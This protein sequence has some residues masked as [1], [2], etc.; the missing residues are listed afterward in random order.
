MDKLTEQR[1]NRNELLS[2]F[3]EIR[4]VGTLCDPL[5]QKYGEIE[6]AKRNASAESPFFAVLGILLGV[7][8]VFLG[9]FSVCDEGIIGHATYSGDYFNTLCLYIPAG[10]LI[11]IACIKW[12]KKIK[13]AQI[14]ASE[15]INRL[16]Q[17]QN[18]ILDEID[19]VYGES[20][21]AGLYPQK[22]LFPDAIEYC[23][24]LVNDMRA[25]SIKEAINL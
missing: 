8:L 1:E 20:A 15:E 14:G 21:I 9:T 11:L 25:D 22:Y 18:E 3:G 10:I 12:Y 13:A 6:A 4:R 5:Y 2:L 23:Y 16:N 7:F 19:R 17:R 24:T